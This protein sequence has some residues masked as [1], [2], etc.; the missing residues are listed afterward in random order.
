MNLEIG[1]EVADVTKYMKKNLALD[2]ISLSFLPGML[3]GIIGPDGAG[4]TTLMRTLIGLLK[5]DA[6]S[7]LF[8]EN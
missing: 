6:G 1:I 8:S 3:H 4:K 7:I 2:G 5:P